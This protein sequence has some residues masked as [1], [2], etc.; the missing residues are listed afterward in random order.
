MSIHD[1]HKLW[2]DSLNELELEISKPNFNTW[3]KN[4]HI[5]KEDQGTISIGVPNEFVKEWLYSKYHKTILRALRNTES[6]VRSVEYVV[7]KN[8]ERAIA[9]QNNT[10]SEVNSLPLHNLY[11]N[12]K[13][14]LNPRYTFDT[15]IIGPFNELAYSAAQ[16]IVKEPSIYNPLF[17]YGN[18]GLGKTHLIQAV[19]NALKIQN[20][21]Y[22]IYYVSSEKFSSDFV[23]A[24]QSNQRN[25]FKEKYSKYDILIMDDVQFLS[26]KE[27]TQEELFHLFNI[28]YDNHKQIMFSSDKHPNYI[29]GLEDRLKSRFSAGMIIDVTK[30][31]YE[32][33][34]A[35]LQTKAQ[36]FSE[37]IPEE[38]LEYIAKNVEGNV[39]E[40]EG[41]LNSLICQMRLKKRPITIQEL[42]N[43]IRNNIKPRRSININEVVESIAKFYNTD[44]EIIYDKTRRK[45]IVRTRQIIMY[46]LREDFNI[47][48]P[49]IGK[50][51]GGRDHTTVIHS[52][53]KITRELGV[54]SLL[55][56]EIE[57]LRT[58]LSD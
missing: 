46:I 15:F 54:D 14:N 6:S 49:M 22:K 10:T 11:I 41:I 25:L 24:I 8:K 51:L 12:K 48:Y 9:Q 4:T 52:C 47:S 56:Q 31:E 18:T 34:Y 32:S 30:P 13:D 28:L 42:K 16:A 38:A 27:K 39:R 21:D 57:Q 2:Q 40:L 5:T 35:I 33:R 17:I 50:R 19:G 58:I 3:F 29:P 43:L 23:H 7:T 55:V 44:P 45:E 53:T 20:P 36:S 37:N 26:G 1:T